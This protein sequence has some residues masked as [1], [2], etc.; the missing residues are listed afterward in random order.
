MADH[1]VLSRRGEISICGRVFAHREWRQVRVCIFYV[2]LHVSVSPMFPGGNKY[3]SVNARLSNQLSRGHPNLECTPRNAARHIELRAFLSVAFLSVCGRW[4]R[5]RRGCA[6]TCTS[7]AR[8]ARN[9]RD[10]CTR[11]G[12]NVCGGELCV[13]VSLSS[14]RERLCLLL[15][16]PLGPLREY[17]RALPP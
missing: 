6:C 16:Q 12:L 2:R 17:C 8:I 7:A 4:R 11:K 14:S 15:V 1:G 10:P 13:A 3:S 9:A 5:E